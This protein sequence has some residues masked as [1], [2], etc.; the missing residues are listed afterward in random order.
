MKVRCIS[1]AVLI[2]VIVP[3]L[4]LGGIPFALFIGL[5][6]IIATKE[7]N[8][9]F[10]YPFIIKLLTFFSLISIVYSNFD[11]NTIIFGLEYE[12]L[13]ILILALTIPIIFYQVKG[14]Y[15]IEDAF[16]L[17]GFILLIGLGLN[18]FILIRSYDLSY[19]VLMLLIPIITDTFAYIAGMKIGKHKVT[20]L[21][22]KKS[23]EGYIVGSL[24][25]TFVMTM[26]YL[27]FINNQSN[28][29]III[30]IIFILTVIGQ[31]G[32]LVFSAVKRQYN[33]KDLSNL[34]PGHG[35]IMDRLD[36]LILVA[37]AFILFLGYL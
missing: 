18:Y 31:V 30:A 20:K 23:W 34:I 26:F 35:G 15:T 7:I 32:D 33:I 17:I 9:L 21:S 19:F 37:I 27:T 14:K 12:Y 13:S 3:L 24:M 25:G 10:K 16:K 4:W 6:A 22:P 36:S 8:D 2:A 1:A 28:L 11:A 5:I 29:L